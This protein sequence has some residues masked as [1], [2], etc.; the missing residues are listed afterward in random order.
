MWLCED[1]LK[2][3]TADVRLPSASQKCAC[4]SSLLDENDE[5]ANEHETRRETL[6]VHAAFA[7]VCAIE[8]HRSTSHLVQLCR[9]V[10]APRSK[11][12]VTLD[13]L[14]F[15]P[16]LETGLQGGARAPFPEQ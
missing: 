4:L 11:E 5:N 14:D 7:L 9:I 12:T 8:P 16:S 3:E 13:R 6:L 2:G 1:K 15:G 10:Q